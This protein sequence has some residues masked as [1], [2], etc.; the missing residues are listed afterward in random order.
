MLMV[1]GRLPRLAQNTEQEKKEEDSMRWH[2]VDR[3]S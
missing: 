2:A 3:D 1:K